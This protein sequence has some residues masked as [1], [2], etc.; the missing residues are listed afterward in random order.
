MHPSNAHE[1]PVSIPRVCGSTLNLSNTRELS[2]AG[3]MGSALLRSCGL[4]VDLQSLVTESS[5]SYLISQRHKHRA[6]VPH[7]AQLLTAKRPD[8]GSWNFEM[9]GWVTTIRVT[10]NG[11]DIGRTALIL[12]AP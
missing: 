2:R 7:L 4:V 1:H 11:K 10:K 9:A 3:Q 8:T 6:G 12:A 5:P